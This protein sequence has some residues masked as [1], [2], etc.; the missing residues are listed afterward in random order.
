MQTLEAH[1]EELQRI[2]RIFRPVAFPSREFR[3][4]ENHD[5]VMALERLAMA[6]VTGPRTVLDSHICNYLIA[7]DTIVLAAA[8]AEIRRLLSCNPPAYVIDDVFQV[9]IL[10]LPGRLAGQQPGGIKRLIDVE[11]DPGLWAK[12]NNRY[13][14]IQ[15]TKMPHINSMEEEN[16][17][18][19]PPRI[20]VQPAGDKQ[21]MHDLMA[22]QESRERT[23]GEEGLPAL[24][25]LAQH[26]AGGGQGGES[27]RFREV[28]GRFLLGLYNGRTFPYDLN[29]LHALDAQNFSDVISALNFEQY[30][31]KKEVHLYI[32]DED[33]RL[34]KII[35][36]RWKN[37]AQEQKKADYLAG[38][39]Q[40][41][42]MR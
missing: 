11:F 4:A 32:M 5:C 37:P 41:V 10:A 15:L 39:P 21:W 13:W 27:D 14:D 23:A 6:V 26:A 40:P 33:P 34:W 31:R 25:R 35:E 1:Y 24:L 8:V 18:D 22:K 12:I 30:G 2:T 28:I 9:L 42:T 7:V 38:Q 19:R 29:S 16:M 36:E 20:P 17:G 3:E